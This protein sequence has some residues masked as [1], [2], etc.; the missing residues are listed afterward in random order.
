MKPWYLSKIVWTN[1]VATLIAVYSLFQVT[2]LF[3]ANWL[4]YFGLVVGVL[5]IVL[6]VWFS[7]TQLTLK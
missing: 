1:V 3:P 6:R 7:D 4:P 5:N 2:P